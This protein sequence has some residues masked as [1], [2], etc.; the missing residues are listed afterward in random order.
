VVGQA[1]NCAARIE[2]LCKELGEP[3]L[4]SGDLARYIDRPLRSRGA[5]LLRGIPDPV[6]VFALSSILTTEP[7]P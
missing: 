3:L 6:E 4:I 2:G 1:V 5:H 7:A